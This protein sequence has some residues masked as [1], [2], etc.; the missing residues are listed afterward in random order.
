MKQYESIKPICKHFKL[1]GKS[2]ELLD[3][4][5]RALEMG[6]IHLMTWCATRMAHFVVACQR[7]GD[8]LVPVYNA[9]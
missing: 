5:M 7:F 4:S 1:S 3:T 8:L 6:G 2:K 9:M